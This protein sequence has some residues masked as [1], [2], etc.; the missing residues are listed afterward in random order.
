MTAERR[1]DEVTAE[2]FARAPENDIGPSLDRI[3]RAMDLLGHP[4]R[5]A[6][7][8][9]ITGTNGKTSTARMIDAL[10]RSVGLR[11]GLYTSP[12]LQSI[13]ERI[14]I[15]GEPLSEERFLEVYADV[16]PVLDLVDGMSAAEGGPRMTFFEAITAMAF[17]A[18]ADAPV[19]VMILEVGLGGAWDATNVADATV[20]VVTPIDL[21]HTDWLGERLAD[22]AGEKAGIIKAGSTALLAHQPTEA[23]EVL[24]QRAVDVGA[25]VAR[26]GLEFG[27]LRSVE[28][29]GGQEVAL[30]G[31]RGQYHQV[32]L[33]LFGAH[34]AANAAMALAAAE[35][36]VGSGESLSDEIV[37]EGLGQVTSPGRL[38][39]L[40]KSP[41]V[42]VD[43]A[44]NP[45][46]ARVLAEAL[47]ASFSF[48]GTVAVLS[49]LEDKD[50]VGILEALDS[51][52][53]HVIATR[54]SSPR[55]LPAQRL[56]ELAAEVFGDHRVTVAPTVSEALEA[57]IE[58]ADERAGEGSVGIVATG[59]VVTAGDI[60]SLVGGAA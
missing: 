30:Q 9:H 44:H 36:L 53:D 41:S 1:L 45:A 19:D 15:D 50:V 39:V 32:F 37:T 23:A 48:A 27:V 55:A 6:P 60:R 43:S 46:G 31:L 16:A 24:L 42:I 28:A 21:D 13:T 5:S 33:P 2:L 17:A 34:Q 18:F 25:T 56:G 40:R 35:A 29:V 58:W 12:H 49:I 7:V 10:L 11:T 54:N 26:E 14:H 57:A 59:S 22:I 38:E 3:E 52:V 47:E 20:A 8:V 51:A 4:E